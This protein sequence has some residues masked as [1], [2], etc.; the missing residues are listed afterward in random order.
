MSDVQPPA[1]PQGDPAPAIATDPASGAAPATTAP[2]DA[3][4]LR[5]ELR[6]ELETQLN[7]RVSGLQSTYQ[8]QINAREAEI[9][10]LKTATMSEDEREQARIE[11]EQAE[12]QSLQT[13]NW[14]LKQ[15]SKYPEA[16]SAFQ[17]ILDAGDN[18]TQLAVLVELLS[19]RQPTTPAPATPEADSLVPD[20]D[21]NNPVRVVPPGTAI[22]SQGQVLDKAFRH[23]Y[24]KNLS[25]W[26][27]S[28]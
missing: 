13:E 2:V 15:S 21:P 20:I 6:A 27:G 7:K 17:R 8:E 24:L 22:G 1:Q 10:R 4:A 9:R 26:P 18:E 25:E 11:E 14:L 19:A 3:E 12:I 16:V 28:R 23:N 5:A